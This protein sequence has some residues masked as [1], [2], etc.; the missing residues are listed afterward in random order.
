MGKK[1]FTLLE[2]MVVVAIIGILAGIAI[3]YYLQ[4]VMKARQSEAKINLSN[5]AVAEISYFAEKNSW[6]PD[7]SIIGWQ[8]QGS[9]KYAYIIQD[10]ATAPPAAIPDNS[11][12][13]GNGQPGQCAGSDSTC[14]SAPGA[15]PAGASN[16]EGFTAHA[17][18]HIDMDEGTVDCWEI[19]TN[20]NPINTLLGD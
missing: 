16:P 10:G 2:L 4:F 18:G 17:I 19:D 3:P 9:T 11:G 13:C 15:R 8:V 20:K 12:G 5:I 6:G 1:G 7:F 14:K